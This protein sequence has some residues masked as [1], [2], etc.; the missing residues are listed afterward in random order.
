[1]KLTG[2]GNFLSD[3]GPPEKQLSALNA[4]LPNRVGWNFRSSKGKILTTLAKR[5]TLW[6]SFRGRENAKTWWQVYLIRPTSF[7][8]KP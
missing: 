2:L 8:K 1:M 5:A 7:Y 6:K 4:E 3:F